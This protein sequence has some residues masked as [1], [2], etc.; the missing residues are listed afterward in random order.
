VARFGDGSNR[1][2]VTGG[3]IG[4]R[5]R[6]VGGDGSNAVTLSSPASDDISVRLRGGDAVVDLSGITD[7]AGTATIDF[8]RAGGSKTFLAPVV[9]SGTLTVRHYP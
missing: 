9:V 8:G 1:L 3:T 6:Y 4:G 5:L 2:T 7:L